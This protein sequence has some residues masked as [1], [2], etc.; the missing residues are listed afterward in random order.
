LLVILLDSHDLFLSTQRAET[1]HRKYL[2]DI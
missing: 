1:S 2:F